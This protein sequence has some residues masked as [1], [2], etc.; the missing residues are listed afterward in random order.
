MIRFQN[1]YYDSYLEKYKN[2]KII[3]Y[4]IGRTFCDFLD[5]QQEK[6]ELLNS[7]DIL[8][9]GDMTKEGISVQIGCRTLS[10]QT[11]ESVIEEELLADRYVMILFLADRNIPYVLK[12]L[13]QFPAFDQMVCLYGLNCKFW[14]HEQYRNPYPAIPVLPECEGKFEIPKRI[15]YC[16]F[17][18]GKI[19][20]KNQECID[21]WHEHCPD[22]EFFL[23]DESRVDLSC[24][25]KYV[26]DAYKA[27]KYAFVSD[28][29]RLLAVHQYGGFYFDTDV[30]LLRRIEELRKYRSV[31]AFMEYGEIA[32]GLGFGSIANTREL[33]EMIQ[34]Y[35][36]VSFYDEKGVMNLTPC[37]RYTN[38]YF[39]R[40][41]VR[42]DNSLQLVEDMLF[43]PS[44]YL[45]PLVAVTCEDGLDQLALY[46]LENNTIGIHLCDNSWRTEKEREAFEKKKKELFVINRRLLSDWKLQ[47]EEIS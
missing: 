25:P 6:I 16:W 11:L 1:L 36:D 35:N 32:T 45:C 23:W 44:S 18:K 47:N 42:I 34:L 26:Q 14:G 19:S 7:I 10:V 15:H 43:L 27:Q 33:K 30:F 22:Y 24:L 39:R 29:V 41:N 37:P 46:A 5:M 2:K 20:E 3:A 31:Y 38:D 12:V 28:Y 8:I 13:D 4:G 9:D 21:S 40:R 17:G